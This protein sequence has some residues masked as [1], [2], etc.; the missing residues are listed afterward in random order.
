MYIKGVCAGSEGRAGRDAAQG[1]HGGRADPQTVCT[2]CGK[3]EDL[4]AGRM[5]QHLQVFL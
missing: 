5:P 2:L 1:D 3:R 4:Q